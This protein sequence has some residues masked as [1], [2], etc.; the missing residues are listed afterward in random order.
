MK[1][2]IKPKYNDIRDLLLEI[3]ELIK[4]DYSISWVLSNIEGRETAA[5]LIEKVI[6]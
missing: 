2:K 4:P 1:L 5:V 6:E 3:Y